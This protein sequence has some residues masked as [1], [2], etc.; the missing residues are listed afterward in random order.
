[1]KYLEMVIKETLRLFP[2]VP[3][4]M[5]HIKEDV[6]IDGYTIPKGANIT[7]APIVMHRDPNLFPDPEIFNP[8]RFSPENSLGR[9]PLPVYFL[10]RW[11]QELYRSEICHAGDEI[12]GVQSA[13]ELQT[14]SGQYDQQNGR[15]RGG[16]S[17]EEYQRDEIKTAP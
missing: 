15:T 10:Q 4:F 13:E 3:I 14:A 9:L 8:E 1:M 12:N 7:L 6:A 16:T 2:S 5:R 17:A 11:S